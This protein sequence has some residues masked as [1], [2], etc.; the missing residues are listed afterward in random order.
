[1]SLYN[2]DALD[3]D[4]T[5]SSARLHMPGRSAVE[6]R[7]ASACTDRQ[8]CR[9]RP[10]RATRASAALAAPLRTTIPPPRSGADLAFTPS[11]SPLLTRPR[12]V[13]VLSRPGH[14]P[15]CAHTTMS[16]LA[17]PPDA[18]DAITPLHQLLGSPNVPLKYSIA[19]ASSW[20]GTY[21][22]PT[23]STIVRMRCT[24]GGR[25][26]RSM[27]STLPPPPLLPQAPAPAPAPAST[28]PPTSPSL[29]VFK[30]TQPPPPHP[31]P[32]PHPTPASSPSLSAALP[33]LA[34]QSSASSR[35]TASVPVMSNAA[36]SASGNVQKQ[37]IILKLDKPS[38]VRSITFGKYHKPHPCN[39]RDFKVYGAT[40]HRLPPPHLLRPR[41]TACHKTPPPWWPQERRH[42]RIL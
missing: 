40:H 26:P 27:P 2:R 32:A 30:A 34:S 31:P 1:M 29:L 15:S 28:L 19:Q 25:A 35:R 13:H 24:R 21:H 37:Y 6:A 10:P 9:H 38:V 41:Q 7:L 12:A 17:P 42:P 3:P 16:S 39:L 5:G 14:A 11:A 23:S 8:M 20:S 33:P 36:A 22:P 4:C 18:S